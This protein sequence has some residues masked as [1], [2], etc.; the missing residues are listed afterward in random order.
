M[1]RMNYSFTE[2]WVE[3]GITELN[4]ITLTQEKK[5]IT[6]SLTYRKS[7][8]FKISRR[9]RGRMVERKRKSE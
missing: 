4:E 2:K 6:F 5:N 3:L 7:L 1:N 8:D 9:A